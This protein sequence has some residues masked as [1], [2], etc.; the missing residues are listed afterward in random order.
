[1]TLRDSATRVALI[2]GA[3]SGIG[4]ATAEQLSRDGYFTVLVA[5]RRDRLQVLADQ[6]GAAADTVAIR[7]LRICTREKG[8]FGDGLDQTTAKHWRG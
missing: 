8:L 1:M 2:T 7:V 6:I 5:R 4:W 3:S